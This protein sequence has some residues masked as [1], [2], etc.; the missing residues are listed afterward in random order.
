MVL[1]AGRTMLAPRGVRCRP[2]V[3]LGAGRTMQAPRGVRCRP[4]VVL[5]AGRTMQ[6]PRGVRCRPLVVLGAGRTMQ[7]PRGVGCRPYDA[8]PS[9]CWVQAVQC[10]PLVVLGAGRTM[11]APRGV[12]CRPYDAGPSWCWVQ[13]VVSDLSVVVS[14]KGDC[15]CQAG[16]RVQHT[17]DWA[18]PA[19][20][21]S[22]QDNVTSLTVELTITRT[23]WGRSRD[24][25]LPDDHV[26]CWLLKV[27]ATCECLS[28]T[29]L[30]RQIYV[31]PHW[32]RSCRSN[33]PS[34]PV[35]VY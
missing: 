25:V 6:A 31:L 28:G 20:T 5:G 10:W 30:L 26:V 18:V 11:L 35:T 17:T 24:T 7:A 9:W 33:F 32:D 27:P 12:G 23:H 34:H 29:D 21:S 15:D 19:P 2:L 13:A 22:G 14:H 1:G 16:Q 4:L 8:G 3:V